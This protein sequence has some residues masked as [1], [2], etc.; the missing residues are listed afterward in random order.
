MMG[1]VKGCFKGVL[2]RISFEEVCYSPVQ[3]YDHKIKYFWAIQGLPWRRD[4]YQIPCVQRR[5]RL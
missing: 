3:L 1:G 4:G 2:K 5:L